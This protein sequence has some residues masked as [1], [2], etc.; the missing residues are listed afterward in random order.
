MVRLQAHR[1]VSSEYP[2]NTLA[3]F[4]AAAEEGY[5][6]VECDLKYT[7]D[8]GLVFLHDRTLDRTGRTDAGKR[9]SAG[10]GIAG[11]TLDEAKRVD[12]GL[13]MGERFRGERMP[14]LEEGL[15]FS[16]R[17]GMPLKIDNC[18]ESFPE[19]VREAMFSAFRAWQGRA[20]VGFTCADPENLR[21]V[22]ARFPQ[23]ELHY[24]GGDLSPERLE[25][26]ARIAA[27][28]PLTVWVCFGNAMTEWFRGTKATKEVCAEVK[29][30]G[31]LGIWILSDPSELIPAI[32][33]FGAQVI[34]TTGHIKPQQVAAAERSID[35]KRI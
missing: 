22:A 17:T 7:K 33:D 28:H 26:V 5:D 24:D 9:L 27:G 35:E 13:W 25:E 14:T 32:R 23:C 4:E 1:G 10:T 16:A 15:A 12:V 20:R 34:E 30:Y 29:R 19:P 2:E 11:L 3:A 6:I 8:G 18:W 31:E 21:A